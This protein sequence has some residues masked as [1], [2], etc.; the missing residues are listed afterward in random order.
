VSTRSSAELRVR[1]THVAP[2]LSGAR[3]AGDPGIE[4]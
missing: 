2:V 1:V 3:W 4:A